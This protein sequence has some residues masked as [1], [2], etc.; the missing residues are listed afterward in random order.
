VKGRLLSTRRTKVTAVSHY[1]PERRVTNKDLEKIVDTSDEWIF[2]R[3][4]IRERR[5]AAKGQASSDLAAAAAKR[6]LEKRGLDPREIDLIIVATVTPD[7]FFPS[8]ACLVQTKIGADN[9]WAFD[10]SGACSGFIYAMTTGAQ[11]VQTGMHSKVLVIGSDVMTSIIDFKDRSTCVLFGDGAGA[12]LLEPAEDGER[13][14]IDFVLRSD[15]AGGQFLHMPAGGSLNPASVETVQRKM[16]YVHQ[17]GRNVFK[18][19]VRGMSDISDEILQR[20]GLTASDLKLYIPHQANLRIINAAV[21]KMKLRKEQ[22]V[23]N[24]DKYANTTAGTI[25]ICLS[26][27][28]ESKALQKNDLVLLASFGA[29]FTWGSL[30]LRWEN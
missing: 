26:E 3:T 25:P 19:A 5:F 29:G 10:L 8:T 1:L 11:F 14:I 15:G 16:H 24:I 21:D 18:F 17:D 13:G 6:L 2:D 23:I 22:V 20:H 27:A 30:L 9:A 28:V 7:M 12:V 4:G